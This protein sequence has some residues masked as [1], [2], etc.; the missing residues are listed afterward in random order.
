MSVSPYLPK[1]KELPVLSDASVT[2]IRSLSNIVKALPGMPDG[3]SGT[4]AR[5]EEAATFLRDMG[6]SYAESKA[7]EARG[8]AISRMKNKAADRMARDFGLA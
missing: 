1:S 2:T 4:N 8:R 7:R 6:I 5:A 3:S